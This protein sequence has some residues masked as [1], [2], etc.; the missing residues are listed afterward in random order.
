M[1]HDVTFAYSVMLFIHL[2]GH[3]RSPKHIRNDKYYKV[4]RKSDSR[5]DFCTQC[6]AFQSLSGHFSQKMLIFA[7]PLMLFACVFT[8]SQNLV[9]PMEFQWFLEYFLGNAIFD[10]C[11]PSNA[12]GR[13]LWWFSSDFVNL[14]GK[15]TVVPRFRFSGDTFRY[16]RRIQRF[17]P[18][19][20]PEITTFRKSPSR[21]PF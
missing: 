20:Q 5:C 15:V 4:F 19:N 11:N 10:F 21:Q 1:N 16:F 8:G 7:T 17:Q 3:F 18:Q 6:N 14:G 9:L 2:F 12:F 13:L